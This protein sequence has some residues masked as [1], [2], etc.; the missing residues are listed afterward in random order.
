M[1][2]FACGTIFSLELIEGKMID[3][4][5]VAAFLDLRGEWKPALVFVL[6][7]AFAMAL[8]GVQISRY[9]RRPLLD[10][11]FQFPTTK[12]IDRNLIIGSMLFG[13]GLGSGRFL[14]RPCCRSPSDR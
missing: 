9:M 4:A 13:L 14:P 5:S 2:S 6:A 3:P 7:G 12:T 1:A 10:A 11:P 8:G